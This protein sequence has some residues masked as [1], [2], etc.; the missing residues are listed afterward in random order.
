MPPSHV[1]ID[2]RGSSSQLYF[3]CM[4]E[5]SRHLHRDI[6]PFGGLL[7]GNRVCVPRSRGRLG[8]PERLVQGKAEEETGFPVPF[9]A[10]LPVTSTSKLRFRGGT[11]YEG[12]TLHRCSAQGI[13]CRMLLTKTCCVAARMP[14]GPAYSIPGLDLGQVTR[15]YMNL[16]R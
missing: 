4:L 1:T 13:L 3:E 15:C 10:R 9:R 11:C 6:R 16:G 8:S 12:R 5:E 7:V 14:G 2:E